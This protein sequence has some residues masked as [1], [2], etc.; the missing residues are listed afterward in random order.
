[1]DC[2]A[3]PTDQRFEGRSYS[4]AVPGKRLTLTWVYHSTV[5]FEKFRITLPSS[6]KL[7]EATYDPIAKR[8][9]IKKLDVVDS[10][11]NKITDFSISKDNKMF[12]LVIR[13]FP[14]KITAP[15]HLK[16]FLTVNDFLVL[17]NTTKVDV[18]VAPTVKLT[19]NNKGEEYVPRGRNIQLNCTATGNPVPVVTIKKDNT[20]KQVSGPKTSGSVIMQIQNIQPEHAGLYRCN[21]SNPAGIVTVDEFI[22]VKYIDM[23]VNAKPVMFVQTTKSKTLTL[24]CPIEGYPP[25]QYSW[26]K[27]NAHSIESR[28]GALQELKVNVLKDEDF[29]NYTCR[30]ESSAGA[31]KVVFSL[32]K[33]PSSQGRGSSRMNRYSSLVMASSM[34]TTCYRECKSLKRHQLLIGNGSLPHDKS[35]GHNETCETPWSFMPKYVLPDMWRIVYWSSQLLSWIIL[36]MMQSYEYAGEFTVAGKIKTA[37]YENAIWYGSYL[38]IFGALLIY[39]AVTPNLQLDGEHLRIIGMTASNTWSLLLLVLLLGYGL[40][41]LPRNAWN[42]SV[43]DRKLSHVLFKISK[44]STEKE[45]VEEQLSDLLENVRKAS[46]EIR[47]NSPLRKFLDIIIKKCPEA[48]MDMFSKA[49]DDYVDYE[50]TQ[51]G[52]SNTIYSEKTLVAMHRKVIVITQRAHRTNVQWSALVHQAFQLEDVEKNRENK[53]RMF[54]SSF[55]DHQPRGSVTAM[56]LKWYWK[57][58]LQPLL[59]KLLAFILLCF[60]IIL[61]WSEMTFF[62]IDPKL[63]IFA[64]LISAAKKE[65]LYFNIELICFFT[66]SYMCACTYYTVFKMRIFN[67]YYFAPKH[68]TDANSLLFSGLLLC[69]LTYAL[70][71][72]FLAMIHLDGHV[73]NINTMEQTSFTAFMGHMDVLGFVS[74]GL[75]VYYPMIV[76]LICFCTYFNIGSRILHCFG[77]QQFL[78]DEDLSMDYVSEG[79][80]IDW[81]QRANEIRQKVS[82]LHHTEGRIDDIDDDNSIDS[83]PRT[84]LNEPRHVKY[85]NLEGGDDRVNLLDEME[86]DAST[87][88]RGSRYTQFGATSAS[89]SR[90][91]PPRNLFDDI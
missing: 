48:S 22:S 77:V 11:L 18:A 60:T 68:Q 57:L 54:K 58:L 89:T 42:M 35:Y 69:R 52:T 41:E 53:D 38:L 9:V 28:L 14:R 44:L 84:R 26:Y 61:V 82:R 40:V 30:A 85:S 8:P 5:V 87:S 81:S 83:N 66:V 74:K 23:E 33:K 43:P 62:S 56:T 32:T 73:T 36:P 55:T 71:L 91:G 39:V 70:C 46:E 3:A 75:N 49:T 6:E 16:C 63:S 79:K 65:Y 37:L 31:R 50:D 88:T 25:P 64:L 13:S 7:W 90:P 76:L 19:L 15:F 1:M 27:Y 67:F 12:T 4:L 24:Q 78:I 51:V 20:V 72:N 10:W 29:G 59:Y 80:D 47:Y 2:L 34:L 21:A 45:E 86:Y 17:D